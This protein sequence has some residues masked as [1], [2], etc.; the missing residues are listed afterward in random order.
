MQ[1]ILRG[2]IFLGLAVWIGGMLFFGAV[3]APV[4]FGSLMP[5]VPDPALGLHLAGTVVRV[6]LLRLHDMG[7]VC[8][9]IL[10]VLTIV[11]RAAKMTY[12]S[13]APH[14]VLLALMLGLTA[15]S[16]YSVIPRMESLRIR[17]GAAMDNPEASDPAKVDFNRLHNLSTR[18]E[19]VVLLCGLGLIFLYARP[20]PAA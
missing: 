3:V 9:I 14:L 6:S 10:L 4:A 8:G 5:M 16:Q 2:L 17:A 19:G 12:R 13:I 11:E 18:L 20:E 15:Y 7:L 1:T